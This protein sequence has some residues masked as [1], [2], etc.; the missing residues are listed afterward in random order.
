VRQIVTFRLDQHA[1]VK[2]ADF[3]L[4]RDLYSR[5]YYASGDRFARLPVRWMAPECLTVA[6]YTVKSDVVGSYLM[7]GS[8][9][10][11][12]SKFY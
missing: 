8:R 1:V 5:D 7:T 2:V 3:G 4:S 10:E 12:E 6:R 11:F 9:A